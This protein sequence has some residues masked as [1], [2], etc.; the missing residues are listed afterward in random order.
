MSTLIHRF[1]SAGKEPVLQPVSYQSEADIRNLVAF[2]VQDAIDLLKLEG[3][4]ENDSLV[5]QFERSLF[6]VERTCWWYV[7]EMTLG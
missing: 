2:A 7:A 1:L 6:V 5:V 3:Y 4:F